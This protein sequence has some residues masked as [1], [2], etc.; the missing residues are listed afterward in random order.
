M[1]GTRCLA[2]EGR[3]GRSAMQIGEGD[4]PELQERRAM[5]EGG[6]FARWTNGDGL[7]IF[8]VRGVYLDNVLLI[9]RGCRERLIV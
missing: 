4:G 6:T 1:L 2:F 7:M 9:C 8:F 3:W 5:I